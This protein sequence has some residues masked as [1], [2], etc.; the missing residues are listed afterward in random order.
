M[1]DRT[2][3]RAQIAAASAASNLRAAEEGLDDQHRPTDRHVTPDGAV[4]TIVDILDGP[5]IQRM[6]DA[7]KRGERGPVRLLVIPKY[8][9]KGTA[10]WVYEVAKINKTTVNLTPLGGG[11]GLNAHAISLAEAD[12]ADVAA[13]EKLRAAGKTVEVPDGVHSGSIVKIAGPGWKQDPD[14]LWTVT[15]LKGMTEV[16]IAR[17]GGDGGRTWPKV[18]ASYVSS[19][20]GPT[21]LRDAMAA[22]PRFAL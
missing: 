13:F 17:L 22:D 19:V 15:A 21:G 16:S 14:A 3:T 11:R 2:P 10:G 1:S 12:D 8:A 6:L 9:P 5:A 7:H 4:V 18:P 20:I